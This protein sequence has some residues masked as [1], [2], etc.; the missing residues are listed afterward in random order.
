MTISLMGVLQL[1][2]ALWMLVKGLAILK[3]FRSYGKNMEGAQKIYSRRVM[4][5]ETEAISALD[6]YFSKIRNTIY[7]TAIHF[8]LAY[9][10]VT[11]SLF[12]A[13]GNS[14]TGSPGWQLLLFSIFLFI[15]PATVVITALL[16]LRSIRED[17]LIKFKASDE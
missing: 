16:D 7:S 15:M 4:A 5:G 17:V 12:T 11:I 13:I 2:L 9:I 6:E 8:G 1:S 10:L 3:P 14:D